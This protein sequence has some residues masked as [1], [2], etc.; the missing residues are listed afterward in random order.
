M[1]TQ[2]LVVGASGAIGRAWL[3]EIHER[4][5]QAAITGT[6]WRNEPAET[7]FPVN[8]IRMN[9]SDAESV[10]GC[11]DQFGQLDLLINAVGFLHTEEQGPEKSIRQ[12]EADFFLRNLQINAL[13]TLLLAKAFQGALRKAEQGW[14][15]TVSAKVGSI[16]D[17]RLGGWYSYRVS[18]AALN[19]A[20][21]TLALE[22][23]R[24]LPRV[25]VAALHPGTVE[26]PLSEPFRSGTPDHKVFKPEYSVARMADVLFS[27]N[28]A[29]TGRL[30]SWDGQPIPW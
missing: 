28:A 25:C 5:P 30:W 9:P 8:W 1:T 16:E 26:S 3:A 29:D 4:F 7:G 2:V 20:L 24:S 15:A 19:M 18:K 6:W 13:P 14:F 22:W 17:N 10:A 21:K 27:K 12:F 11:A 23:K